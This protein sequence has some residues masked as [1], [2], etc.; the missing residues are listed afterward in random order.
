MKRLSLGEFIDALKREDQGFSVRYDFGGL[1]PD[2]SPA[3]Y[4]GYYEDLAVG[5]SDGDAP[6]VAELVAALES[7]IGKTFCGYKGGDYRMDRNTTL[8]VA[9]HGESSDTAIVGLARCNWCSV[10]ETAWIEERC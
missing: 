9:N 1:V 3:S 2:L 4:R 7:A 8:W 5:F 10:V 6:T